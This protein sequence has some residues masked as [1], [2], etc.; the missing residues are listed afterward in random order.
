MSRVTYDGT[1][2]IYRPTVNLDS[3]RRFQE[4]QDADVNR[5]MSSVKANS[6]PNAVKEWR[7]H[8]PDVYKG[9][10]LKSVRSYDEQAAQ[11][12]RKAANEWRDTGEPCNM[13]IHSS[14]DRIGKTWALYAWLDALVRKG[15][16]TDPL[17]EIRIIDET[18]LTDDMWSYG[19][20]DKKKTNWLLNGTG[21]IAID[22]IGRVPRNDK[23]TREAW[24]SLF[25]MVSSRPISLTFVEYQTVG[26]TVATMVLKEYIDKMMRMSVCVDL[27]NEPEGIRRMG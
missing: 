20:L 27:K 13:F 2:V 15:V 1:E 24:S 8:V 9:A 12:L 21:M 5:I 22:N 16:F 19:K 25:S 3:Y 4:R 26:N 23:I 6:I 18:W 7:S 17:N 11:A 14:S 10:T